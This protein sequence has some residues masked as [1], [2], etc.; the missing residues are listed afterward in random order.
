MAEAIPQRAELSIVHGLNRRYGSEIFLKNHFK[1]FWA[2]QTPA[3]S[4][5]ILYGNDSPLCKGDLDGF[6]IG[7]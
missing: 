5:H 4:R 2:F 7:L 3:K 1:V 6:G